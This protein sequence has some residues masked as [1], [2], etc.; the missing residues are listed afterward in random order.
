MRK[1]LVLAVALVVLAG[2]E[3]TATPLPVA[4][5]ITD[6]PAPTSEVPRLR[7]AYSID[8]LAMF[9]GRDTLAAHAELSIYDP[10]V[11]FQTPYDLV[12]VLGKQENLT[13]APERITIRLILD[14]TQPP[15][16]DPEVERLVRSAFDPIRLAEAFAY[17]SAAPVNEGAEIVDPARVRTELANAG[18]PDGLPIT[19]LVDHLPRSEVL[20]DILRPF[21]INI[22]LISG[23]DTG[24]DVQFP[25]GDAN[26]FLTGSNP[27][28]LS[29]VDAEN[30]INLYSVPISYRAADRIALTFDAQGF[31]V[32]QP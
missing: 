3:Q 17:L 7:F 1:L 20:T 4:L 29:Q 5:Q 26:A 18:Y 8:A 23:D 16:D 2:C 12:V 31:P 25:S 14:T 32:P 22:R 24:S 19:V 15:L 11:D 21:G 10:S 28:W 13:L 9:A 27:T 6:T 30:V